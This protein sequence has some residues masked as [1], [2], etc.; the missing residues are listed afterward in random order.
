MKVYSCDG[1]AP[2]N[3]PCL[4]TVQQDEE[5]PITALWRLFAGLE[6]FP[7]ELVEVTA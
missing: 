1:C 3:G 7:I 4:L 6:I 2:N 5:A